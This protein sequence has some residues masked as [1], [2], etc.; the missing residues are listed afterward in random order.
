MTLTAN[1]LDDMLLTLENEREFYDEM[2]TRA[3]LLHDYLKKSLA[4]GV[5]SARKA[6]ATATFRSRVGQWMKRLFAGFNPATVVEHGVWTT[7]AA[8]YFFVRYASE[9][10]CDKVE[11]VEEAEARLSR[12]F[13]TYLTHHDLTFAAHFNT[14]KPA[15]EIVKDYLQPHDDRFDVY[16]YAAKFIAAKSDA[17]AIDNPLIHTT[18]ENETMN[19]T[20]TI[21]TRVFILGNSAADMTDEQIFNHIAR[22]EGEI[23]KL[24]EINSRP[25]KLEAKL[26]KME[27]DIAALAK[28][29]DER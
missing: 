23:K 26:A 11:T 20:P 21:E 15:P 10:G 17:P 9:R 6:S 14:A 5:T 4:T 8:Q 29:V 28:Y 16:A 24:K 25:K 27:E 7:K 13:E 2:Y 18:P 1:S 12:L 22:I 19:N 3:V